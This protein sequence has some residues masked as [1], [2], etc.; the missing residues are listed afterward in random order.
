MSICLYTYFKYPARRVSAKCHTKNRQTTPYVIS[1]TR[2]IDSKLVRPRNKCQIPRSNVICRI[3]EQIHRSKIY[4]S[5]IP[6]SPNIHTSNVQ[7][8]MTSQKNPQSTRTHDH[9]AQII[10]PKFIIQISHLNVIC[11]LSTILDYIYGSVIC[12][13]SSVNCHTS[14]V[15]CHTSSV[16]CQLSAHAQEAWRLGGWR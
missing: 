1:Q 13:L 2:S 14:S 8:A 5:H 4:N 15:N 10:G 9:G 12:Q 3:I 7:L 11:H 16:S 6:R